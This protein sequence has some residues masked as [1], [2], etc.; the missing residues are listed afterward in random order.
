MTPMPVIDRQ[1]IKQFM[2]IEFNNVMFQL[3]SIDAF[4]H[5]NCHDMVSI[6]VSMIDE[7]RCKQTLT[8]LPCFGAYM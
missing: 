4:S 5:S 6:D 2:L 1:L 8:S 7:N 3:L